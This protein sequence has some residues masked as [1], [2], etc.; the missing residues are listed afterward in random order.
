MANGTTTATTTKPAP[1]QHD[2]QE[3][4]RPKAGWYYRCTVCGGKSRNAFVQ[5]KG[6]EKAVVVTSTYVGPSGGFTWRWSPQGEGTTDETLAE[7]KAHL[8]DEGMVHA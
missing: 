2:W 1:H 7:L 8:A 3:V 4:E 5:P 6:F